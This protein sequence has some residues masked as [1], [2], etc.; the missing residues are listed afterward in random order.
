MV[1]GK[2]KVLAIA[3]TIDAL[4]AAWIFMIDSWLLNWWLLANAAALPAALITV[5]LR[6]KSRSRALRASRI[7]FSDHQKT[8][9]SKYRTMNGE[10]VK[11]GGERMIAD[12]FFRHKIRYEYEKPAMGASNRRIA[13]PDFYLPDY[14]IYVE[15]WGMVNTEDGKDRKEYQKGMEWKIARY[16]EADIKFISIYPQEIEALD[17]V[18]QK[19]LREVT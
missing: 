18:F 12:Y 13:R 17:S 6:R 15:Y 16:R 4:I 3:L 5:L 19:K 14:D 1:S 7:S 10:L 2:A 8:H 11:S 9:G